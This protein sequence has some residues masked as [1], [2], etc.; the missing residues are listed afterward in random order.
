MHLKKNKKS[1][2]HLTFVDQDEGEDI[3][4]T[5]KQRPQ[6]IKTVMKT[7]LIA[8][9][10]DGHEV[11]LEGWKEGMRQSCNRSSV[12]LLNINTEGSKLHDS[13][14]LNTLK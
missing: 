13:A 1:E 11:S 3:K 10:A 4:P 7:P 14:S 6:K 12:E 2:I 9:K 5:I 8:I